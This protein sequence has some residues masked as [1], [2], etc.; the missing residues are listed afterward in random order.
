MSPPSGGES[1]YFPQT[2]YMST[3]Y[4]Y[5]LGWS[6]RHRR[7]EPLAA[8]GGKDVAKYGGKRG[9]CGVMGV[10]TVLGREE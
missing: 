5:H 6:R 3:I 2:I 1:L 7:G 8:G 10:E 9:F 4:K